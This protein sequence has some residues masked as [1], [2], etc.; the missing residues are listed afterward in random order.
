MQRI[1]PDV[2]NLKS[3]LI[4]NPQNLSVQHMESL[5]TLTLIAS[6]K[7]K[8]QSQTDAKKW[9]IFRCHLMNHLVQLVFFQLF[10]RIAKCTDSRKNHFVCGLNLVK[11]TCDHT[12]FSEK[13]Q[14][15]FHAF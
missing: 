6:L 7:E 15:F 13:M 5:Y 2:R 14:C 1:P 12:V 9:L 4:R 8:L 11:I 10:H 3:R